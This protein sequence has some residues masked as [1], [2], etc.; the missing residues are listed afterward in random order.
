MTIDE[1]LKLCDAALAEA[2][3]T[4]TVT[5]YRRHKREPKLARALRDILTAETDRPSVAL[6]NVEESA[7]GGL[8]FGEMRALSA[9]LIRN[10]F[11]ADEADR[12]EP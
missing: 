11:S 12:G 7:L 3:D 2:G 8:S 4:G 9:T 10:S 5:I 1:L 6:M